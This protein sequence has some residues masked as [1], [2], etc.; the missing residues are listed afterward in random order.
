MARSTRRTPIFG[1]CCA[2]SDRLFKRQAAR[3]LRFAIRIA[4]RS[5][6]GEILPHAQ[7]IASAWDS[8]KD[9][10]RWLGDIP[11]DLLEPM[12]RK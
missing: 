8:L 10:K 11:P 2:P 3:R 5:G 12:M 1:N 6:D 9:G 4:L 7:E